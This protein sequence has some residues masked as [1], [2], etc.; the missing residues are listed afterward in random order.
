MKFFIPFAKDDE[1]AEQVYGSIKQH[2]AE[3]LGADFADER[4][5]SIRY[6]HDGNEYYAE[7]GKLHPMNGEPVIAILYEDLR[8]LYHVCTTNRGVARGGSI[9]AGAWSVRSLVHFT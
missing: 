5:F 1:Q 8:R 9:L 7:V 2:L 4:I 6:V 3:S